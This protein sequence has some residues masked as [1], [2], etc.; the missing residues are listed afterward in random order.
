MNL[1]ETA[2]RLVTVV[3]VVGLL[4]SA[5]DDSSTSGSSTSR[6][7]SLGV[8]LDRDELLARAK[9]LNAEGRRVDAA[10]MLDE[11]KDDLTED[12][13][14]DLYP[15]IAEYYHAASVYDKALK[16]V[17]LAIT[18][19]H[20]STNL[21]FIHGDSLRS[22]RRLTEARSRLEELLRQD[23]E[24]LGGKLALARVLVRVGDPR[25]ALPLFESYLAA[26]PPGGPP[27]RPASL[28]LGR[29]LRAIKEYRRASDTFAELLVADPFDTVAYSELAQTFYR[30]RMRQEG[31]FVEQIYKAISQSAF[32]EFVEKRLR[33]SGMTSFALGQKAVNQVRQK[34][35]LQA[36]RNYEAAMRINGSDARLRIF[37]ANLCH[38]FRRSTDGRRVLREALAAGA[39]PASG[40]WMAKAMIEFDEEDSAAGLESSRAGLAALESEGDVGGVEKGQGNSLT[41]LLGV[42]RGL[43]ETGDPDAAQNA[44]ERASARHPSAWEPDYWLGRAELARTR[45]APAAAAFSRART[46]GAG[47]HFVDLEYWSAVLLVD[48]GDSQAAAEK[49]AKVIQAKPGHEKAYKVLDE[50]FERTG[51]RPSGNLEA[52]HGSILAT[53]RRIDDLEEIIDRRPLQ[54]V[55]AEYLELG[56]LYRKLRDPIAFDFF[57]LSSELLPTNARAL[58]QLITGMA[59]PQDIFMRL[60][61]LHRL[62]GIEPERAPVLAEIAGIYVRLNLRL[63]IARQLA[64]RLHRAAPSAVSYRLVGEVELRDGNTEAGRRWLTEGLA[65]YPGDARLRK[66]LSEMTKSQIP[67]K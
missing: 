64:E 45:L 58:Q 27:S 20:Q 66:A 63:D 39:V 9:R 30:R 59:R 16:S 57:F 21:L 33:A 23:P 14:R 28:D 8:G 43:L 18:A 5:C 26:L 56:E 52:T 37:Y 19:G 44:V 25:D 50:I 67:L 55:G 32:E 42:A 54:D 24:H 38:R 12:E 11:R 7:P 34:R 10:R 17:E 65:K 6:A 22:Q 62:L 31:K 35:Y 15:V 46:R 40:L 51:D 13:R 1:R 49:L 61:C 41:L 60:Q 48:Q 29:A 2:S 53:V 47:D 36:F 3:T 4:V